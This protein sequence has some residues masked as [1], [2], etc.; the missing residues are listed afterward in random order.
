[1]VAQVAAVQNPKVAGKPVKPAYRPHIRREAA[2][3]FTVQSERYV[4]VLYTQQ[5]LDN[6][7]VTCDCTA[8]SFGRPCKHA[9]I[10]AAYMAYCAKPS[11]LRPQQEEEVATAQPLTF[12]EM[13]EEFAALPVP[14]F[15]FRSLAP[16]ALDSYRKPA[17]SP[18]PAA[19]MEC[20]G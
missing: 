16:I 5:V 11:H 9:R 7:H 18:A 2:D 14:T 12:A 13:A 6:G 1:M 8:G 20:F 4:H 10:I 19:L 3:T 17:Y 15:D